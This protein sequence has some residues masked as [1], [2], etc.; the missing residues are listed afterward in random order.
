MTNPVTIDRPT[1]PHASRR[2][3]IG[4]LTAAEW[5]KIKTLPS[6]IGLA[7]LTVPV[8][9]AMTAVG[10]ISVR[11]AIEQG[12]TLDTGDWNPVNAGT[13]GIDLGQICVLV[14]A[15]LAT[16]AEYRTGTIVSTLLAVPRRLPALLAKALACCGLIAAV[17]LVSSVLSFSLAQ[18]LLGGQGAP[19]LSADAVRVT[20]GATVYLVLCCALAIGVTTALR[21]TIAG[22]VVVLSIFLVLPVLAQN[23]PGLEGV[24]PFLPYIAGAQMMTVQNSAQ[25][26]SPLLGFVTLCAWSVL[27]LVLGGIVQQ[28]RDV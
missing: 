6:T 25:N 17:G 19:I 9:M 22:L 10:A 3:D 5:I 7:L 2:G 28:R 21:S 16:G 27:A 8:I 13:S 23:I 18:V 4:R 26:L 15:V 20:L 24:A 14:F 11:R 12:M 1:S